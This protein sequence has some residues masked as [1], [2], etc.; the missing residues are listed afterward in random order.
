MRKFLSILIV[1]AALPALA[2]GQPLSRYQSIIDR[3]MF[4]APPPG[5]DPNL[6]PN[7]VKATRGAEKELTQEQEKLQS[8]IHFSMINITPSG[9]TAVG[10]TDKSDP[11][12]EVHY[13]LKVGERRNGWEVKEA[14]PVR[15][16]M[17]IAKGDIE[18]ELELGANSAQG[19]KTVKAASAAGSPQ[20]AAAA[21]TLPAPATMSTGVTTGPVPRSEL[22][23]NGG[24]RGR[25]RLREEEQAAREAQLDADRKRLEAE[26]AQDREELAGLREELERQR[27]ERE[28]REAEQERERA[29]MMEQV[30]A[31]QGFA[32][33]PPPPPE[34]REEP[35][36]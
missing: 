27:E 25:R 17:R 36:P 8:A 20:G 3:Q 32:F 24:L 10:F 18:V 13:Y 31:T 34:V 26:R 30:R 9:E 19:G 22:L 35:Q 15:A 33:P 14:D 7:E 29:A 23:R 11:S 21:T 2:S 16:W 28:A 5:F 12:G 1:L 6:N 4:G